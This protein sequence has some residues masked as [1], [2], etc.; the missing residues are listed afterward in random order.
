MHNVPIRVLAKQER[1][2]SK[3]IKNNGI[4]VEQF[5]EF[6]IDSI[7]VIFLFGVAIIS[8]VTPVLGARKRSWSHELKQKP[9][10]SLRYENSSAFR[11]TLTTA[12]VSH[13]TYN[14]L[15]QPVM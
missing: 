9:N 6:V 5:F 14:S 7:G 12:K 15:L 1:F 13:H 2:M 8:F 4:Y 3:F 11:K 10:Q